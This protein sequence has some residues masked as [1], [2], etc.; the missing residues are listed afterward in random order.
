MPWR[1]VTRPLQFQ[2]IARR[3]PSAAFRNVSPRFDNITPIFHACLLEGSISGVILINKSCALSLHIHTHRRAPG[4]PWANRI[5]ICRIGAA[6]ESIALKSPRVYVCIHTEPLCRLVTVKI[7]APRVHSW[8]ARAK[9][10]KKGRVHLAML[11]LLGPR[12]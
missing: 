12:T 10:E 8:R 5:E 4:S 3:F 6:A 1:A 7:L 11:T 9:K 2:E